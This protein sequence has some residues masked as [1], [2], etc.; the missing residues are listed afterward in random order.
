VVE[1]TEMAALAN[2]TDNDNNNDRQGPIKGLEG[3]R[4]YGFITFIGPKP[5]LSNSKSADFK[6]PS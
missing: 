4:H 6:W 3:L 2:N 5:V 1:L